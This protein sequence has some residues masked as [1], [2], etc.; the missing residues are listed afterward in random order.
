MLFKA[1]HEAIRLRILKR[2]SEA[3]EEK[4][5]AHKREWTTGTQYHVTD[6]LT[7]S[8]WIEME[9]RLDE[10]GTKFDADPIQ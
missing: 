5:E 3:S 4:G 7:Q 2:D 9:F 10:I 1:S 6:E 8:T